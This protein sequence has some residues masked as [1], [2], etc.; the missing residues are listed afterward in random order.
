M[1]TPDPE[2]PKLDPKPWLDPTTDDDDERRHTTAPGPWQ[3]FYIFAP[4]RGYSLNRKDYP[5]A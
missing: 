4:R 2:A 1:S 3:N 5:N